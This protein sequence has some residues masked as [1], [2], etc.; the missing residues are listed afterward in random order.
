MC[1]GK[2]KLWTKQV[3]ITPL[4]EWVLH[5]YLLEAYYC[6]CICMLAIALQ[7]AGFSFICCL[8]VICFVLFVYMFIYVVPSLVVFVLFVLP[9]LLSFYI[10]LMWHVFLSVSLPFC[11]YTPPSL[12]LPLF[13]FS[14]GVRY[15]QMLPFKLWNIIMICSFTG[16]KVI[17]F[18]FRAALVWQPY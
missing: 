13:L 10:Y 11:L 6:A 7:T 18:N 16:K 3:S 1:H 17:H 12:S 4:L 15:Y 2:S 8:C 5:Y 14:V 9:Y